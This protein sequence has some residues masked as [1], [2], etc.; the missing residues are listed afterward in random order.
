M[1]I[2]AWA[3]RCYIITPHQIRRFPEKVDFHT[4]I[5]F[6]DGGDAR[7][8]DGVCAGVDREAV[9]TNLGVFYAPMKKGELGPGSAAIPAS[10]LKKFR[11]IPA[12][13]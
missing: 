11:L 8:K 10:P 3:N 12:G 2:A 13:H 1:E 4:S 5:G 6:L 7:K 9:V